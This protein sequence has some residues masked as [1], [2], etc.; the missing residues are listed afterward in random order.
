LRERRNARESLISLDFCYFYFSTFGV[1]NV[2]AKAVQ[3]SG[4]IGSKREKFSRKKLANR[5]VREAES[6]P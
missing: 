1:E 4:K 3:S 2:A 6:E 5:P